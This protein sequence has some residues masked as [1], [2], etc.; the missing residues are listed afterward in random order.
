[1]TFAALQPLADRAALFVALRQDALS[2]AADALGDH[3][4]DADMAAGTLTFT[5]NDDPSRQLATRSHLVATIAPGPRSLLWA[6]AHPSGDPQGI[7]AQLRA[8]GEQHGIAELTAAEVPFPAD[9]SGDED[10]I[11]QAAHTIG[12]VAVELT[13]RAPYYSA[14]VG[15]GTRAVFLLDAPLP[16]LTVAESV[17][18][19]PRILSGTALSDARTSVW[20]LAR[21]AGWTLTWTDESFSGAEV[22]DATGTATFRFDEQA[23]IAGIESSLR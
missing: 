9:A 18:A 17:V 1:M 7:A 11:A 16:P 19:L 2:A 20:D 8:Y 3:R 4:W 10:W 6:W 13:G 5:A 12:G 14:P 22:A 15:N 21:L 23:R